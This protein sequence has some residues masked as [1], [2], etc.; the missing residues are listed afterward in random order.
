MAFTQKKFYNDAI[1]GDIFVGG[2]IP[3]ALKWNASVYTKP[4]DEYQHRDVVL[5]SIYVMPTFTVGG[6]QVQ[7]ASLDVMVGGVRI[8]GAGYWDTTGL[9]DGTYYMMVDT[10][11]AATLSTT[12]VL[13]RLVV[14]KIVKVGESLT[15]TPRPA[16]T[17]LLS[18]YLWFS[19]LNAIR[20]NTETVVLQYTNDGG[21]T[22]ANLG[23]G[24]S[25]EDVK[26]K[27]QASD[28]ITGYWRD[29][30]VDTDTVHA[31]FVTDE[32]YGDQVLLSAGAHV[33][34]DAPDNP[35]PFVGEFWYDADAPA[36]DPPTGD[37]LV[38]A[39]SGDPT[40]GALAAKVD[41]ATIAVDTTAHVLHVKD[42]GI[43]ADQLADGAVT[44]AKLATAALGSGLQ[45][46]SG[47]LGVH[48]GSGLALDTDGSLKATGVGPTELCNYQAT[49]DLH[50]SQ[51]LTPGV[52]FTLGMPT[53]TIIV[54]AGAT[55][56]DVVVDMSMYVNYASAANEVGLVLLVDGTDRYEL[57]H[58]FINFV[59]SYSCNTYLHG[60]HVRIQLA[61]GSHTL[62]L[63]VVSGV[64]A[65][66]WIVCASNPA[67]CWLR[68]TVD[69]R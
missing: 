45:V 67:V 51:F 27:I 34:S 18:G 65:G 20:V 61:P 26:F 33:G 44:A 42:A 32:T 30:V 17:V 62:Q 23:S 56:I 31:D 55:E 2:E 40:A 11:G 54:P 6:V 5:G 28:G 39:D 60:G 15:P 43:G 22:W 47:V 69:A 35:A 41:D 63:Q 59:Y 10:A 53:Q 49:T 19:A 66:I 4:Q 36:P 25:S 68:M 21:V 1:G 48:V 58:E 16:C 64:A 46:A 9:S 24:G 14:G 57:N 3:P 29:K 8:G 52:L 50:A 7:C 37:H 12:P 13:N 38:L